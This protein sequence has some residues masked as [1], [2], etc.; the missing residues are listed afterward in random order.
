MQMR[1]RLPVSE[2][3]PGLFGSAPACVVHRKPHVCRR[4][5]HDRHTEAGESLGVKFVRLFAAVRIEQQ[6]AAEHHV[7]RNGPA[8]SGVGDVAGPPVSLGGVRVEDDHVAAMAD[9][10]CNGAEDARGVA[11]RHVARFGG[12][13]F[14]DGRG[15]RHGSRSH[16]F[17]D[18]SPHQAAASSFFLDSPCRKC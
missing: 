8:R 16:L 13:G 12:C 2:I 9:D 5:E 15:R 10:D 18:E 3:V 7:N 11:V 17:S 6:R 14:R 1:V 4:P